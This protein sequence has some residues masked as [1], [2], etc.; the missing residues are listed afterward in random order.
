VTLADG[1]SIVV[2]GGETVRPDMLVDMSTLND[3]HILS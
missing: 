1:R 3:L 2:F